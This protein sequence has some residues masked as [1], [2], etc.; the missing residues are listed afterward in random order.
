MKKAKEKITNIALF[1]GKKVRKVWHEDEWWFVAE[2]IV[3]ALIESNDPKQYIQ[4]MKQ[5][6]PELAKGW[7]QI[8][9]TLEV[10]TEGGKQKMICTNT[11]GA[12]RIIQSIPSPKAEPFKR[13]LA[14]VGHERI[15][16]IE[17]PE[18]AANRAREIYRAK[19]YPEG[20]IEKRMRGIEVRESLTSEW[21]NRGAKEGI[22]YAILT[23]EILNG[24][25]E[26]SADDYKKLKGL[27]RE[28]LR[29][30]M[31]DLE[32]ILTML[33]EAA[34]TRIHKD[35]N[36][37]G[38]EKL[39]DDAKEGGAVAGRTRKDIEKRTGKKISTK[40]NFLRLK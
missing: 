37:K 29:D 31:D 32:L 30:H 23:N 15:K 28:N 22:E 19:G 2:D 9:H 3:L 13:W 35:R 38:F 8:V 10:P 25:F 17:D 18:L 1:E 5:R 33:G 6:D 16:E 27:K 14:K 26:M 39:K 12:F 4:R 24:T 21:K 7:V 40:N 11:E 34:T 36:T 20:W